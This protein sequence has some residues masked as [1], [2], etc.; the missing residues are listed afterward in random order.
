MGEDT[1]RVWVWGALRWGFG[2]SAEWIEQSLVDDLHVPSPMTD[3]ERAALNGDDIESVLLHVCGD[4]PEWLSVSFVWV[5]GDSV[6]E[7]GAVFAVLR[8]LI[9]VRTF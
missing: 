1:S 4:F 2:Q 8:C 9:C 5:F 3:V 7:E 6:A